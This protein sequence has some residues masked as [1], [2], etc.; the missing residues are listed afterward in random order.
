MKRN[1]RTLCMIYAVAV[2]TLSNAQCP[3]GYNTVTLNWDYLD[4]LSYTGNYTSTNYY[5]SSNAL[6]KTQRFGFGTQGV[7][8]VHNYADANAPGENGNNTAETGAYGT[9]DDVQFIGNGTVIF[10]FDNAVQ[11]VKFSLFDVDR[12]QVITVTALS[13]ATAANVTLT[14]VSGTTLTI[15]GTATAPTAT[16]NNTTLLNSN[17][18]GTVNVDI[19]GPIT[20]FTITVTLSGTCSGGGCGTGGSEDGSYWVSD[21]TACSAG[22]FPTSYYNVSK[23]FTGQASYVLHAFDNDVYAVN[24]ATGV[25]RLLFSDPSGNNI[26]SMGYDPYNRVLYYVYSLTS[27]AGANKT[28][29]KYDFNTKTIST[30]LADVTTIGI[31]VVTATSG[32]SSR[33]TGVESGA[34]AFYDG[35]LYLGIETTNKSSS[36]STLA[37]SSRESVIWRIDFNG[38]NVPYRASQVFALPVDDGG[39]NLTH[40]WSDFVIND[41]ILYDFDGTAGG[42]ET[43]IFQMNLLTG[44][45]TNF[46]NPA[47]YAASTDRFVP[48]QVAIDWAGNIYN[49]TATLPGGGTTTP[50]I[51]L[52]NS[53]TGKIGTKN[54][55]TSNPAYA[56]GPSFGDAAE[57][58]RWPV[59]FG[60]APASYDPVGSDPGVN[61]ISSNLYLG[62]NKDEEV[63]TRGQTA[64]AN[65]DN[66]DDGLP[67]VNVFNP[68]S[69][70]YLTS[71]NVFNNTGANATVCAWLDYNGNGV[72]DASEGY[73]VTVPSSASTQSVYLY[74]PYINSS[75][76]MGS[77]TYLR[78]RV[79][80]SSNGMTTSSP[81]GY[82][83]NGEIE[84]YRISVNTF[85]LE[86]QLLSFNAEKNNNKVSLDWQTAYEQVGTKYELQRSSDLKNWTSIQ[87][88]TVN[89]VTT[90]HSYID[91]DPLP[92]VSYYRLKTQDPEGAVT[93]SQ[94]RKIEYGDP[95]LL[96]LAPNPA[97]NIV[98]LNIN[99]AI[100]SIA[101]LQVTDMNGK[102]VHQQSVTLQKGGNSI[103]LPFVQKLLPG[104]Y[105]VQLDLD[106]KT[107]TEKLIV[108]K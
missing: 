2:A 102:V 60:D 91:V 7:T 47:G 77:Y 14:K 6:S 50:Y 34:A 54:N 35:A 63:V 108:R 49:L 93:Y 26:N 51:A 73:S 1:L 55:I 84:D 10:T 28:I 74:W 21:I 107:Y 105:I 79:T 97:H 52:Y 32:V 85:P 87:N 67:M 90:E 41:G 95:L 98:K 46:N 58:F 96:K 53:A 81:T 56:A 100:T 78:I 92:G 71:V 19:V 24:P 25:T 11:N 80:S 13:G 37:T 42:S 17:T 5:L 66:Y 48:G 8:I 61:E 29:K 3:S 69:H 33:G 38:S 82:F 18:D 44:V 101:N 99:N 106:T 39:G 16:A 89:Q 94:T 65:S 4:Y 22:S 86:V 45:T 68:N 64:L 62:S 31:P 76:A 83:N 57:G 70:T 30:V 103:A 15:G 59:D 75:L 23:P 40:D 36:T 12:A 27:N 88:I 72:F 104:V 20:S 9:G 43:D